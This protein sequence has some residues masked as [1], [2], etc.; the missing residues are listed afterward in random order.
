VARKAV[1][2]VSLCPSNTEIV[3]AL[4]RASELVGLDR[5]SDWPPD[6]TALPRV[7][8]DLDVDVDAIAALRPDLVL[9]SSS[10]PGMEGNLD[11]LD[12]AGVP[13]V[14][15]DAQSI[16]GVYASILL[17]GR[18]LGEGSRA[19]AVVATMRAE[20][21][22]IRAGAI[23]RA[24]RPRVYLEWWPKPLIAPG[25][26][27]WTTEMIAIAGGESLFADRDVRSGIVEAEEVIARAPEVMLTC[28]CGVPHE[29]QKPGSLASRPGW[30][31]LPAA[32]AG[33]VFAA[34]ERFFGRPGPRVVEGARWLNAILS[35]A[36]A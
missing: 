31:E 13:H 22:A 25:A 35:E 10:V 5:S 24:R 23:S 29:R 30:E 11:R 27:C 28:W 9:S 32:R 16:D 26:R 2:I 15:V 34:E 4:G 6:I 3:A 1:R 20:L 12:A 14:V 36:A 33:R 8:P 21:D 18:L 7:G 17:V 19:R